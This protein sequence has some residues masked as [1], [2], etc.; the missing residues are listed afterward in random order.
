MLF[1]HDQLAD[2]T[3]YRV[4]SIVEL[5]TRECVWAWCMPFAFARTTWW[6][7]SA[8]FGTSAGCPAVIQGDNCSEFTSVALDHWCY[9]QQVRLDFSR[10]GRACPEFCV[11]AEGDQAATRKR[12]PN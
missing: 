12:S 2:G 11:C 6:P 7:R 10:P 5:H 9:R 1:I 8:N 3:A 4:L